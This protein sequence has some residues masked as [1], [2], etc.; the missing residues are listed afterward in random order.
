LRAGLFDG[1]EHGAAIGLQKSAVCRAV[2]PVDGVG[3]TRVARSRQRQ[4]VRAGRLDRDPARDHAVFGLS[5]T[6]VSVACAPSS[7][8]FVKDVT[9][10]QKSMSVTSSAAK[11][12]EE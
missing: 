4:R 12:S 1:D 5:P 8:A 11:N 10:L 9:E 2:E 3:K 6:I 7:I